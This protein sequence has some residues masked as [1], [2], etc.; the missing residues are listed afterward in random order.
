[1]IGKL[2]LVAGCL[3]VE[4]SPGSSS[5]LVIWPPDV[6]LH[7]NVDPIEIRNP[8][9]RVVARVGE[10]VELGGAESE[11]GFLSQDILREPIPANCPG[12][13]W[14][15]N[16]F[17]NA[18]A[19]PPTPFP[20][21]PVPSSLDPNDPLVQD[22]QWYAN[23]QGITLEEAVERLRLQDSSGMLNAELQANERDTFAGMWTQHEP[24]YR[25]VVAFTRNG[26][27][28]IRPYI[29]GGPLEDVIEVRTARYTLAEL[30]A[31]HAETS[32]LLDEASIHVTSATNVTGNRVEVYVYD[33]AQFE[34]ALRK[35]NIQL[36]EAV[37]AIASEGDEP[38]P[39]TDVSPTPLPP[40]INVFFPQPA[41]TLGPGG[42]G[43]ALIIGTL[44]NDNGCLRVQSQGDDGSL[45]VW[46]RDVTL[47][48][49]HDVIEV[50]TLDGK[51]V[52]RVGEQV[53]FGG[54]GISAAEGGSLPEDLLLE[55]WAQACPGPYW[56][57]GEI[58]E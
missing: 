54:G 58:A 17:E 28:T 16:P 20:T 15:T 33:T 56:F 36:P 26:E 45:V 11:G 35:A 4:A 44:V 21:Q 40:G 53:R 29:E 51:V 12:P 24:E 14:L 48:A 43:Q 30:E 32:R 31:A 27:E 46:S 22:A 55:P 3:R 52:A 18:S 5:L 2:V 13:Y 23:D 34:E 38:V 49:S 57:V 50:H 39:D 41:P 25:I 9:G 10:P 37:T 42:S 47:H 1:M 8:D 19:A 7:T 6:T